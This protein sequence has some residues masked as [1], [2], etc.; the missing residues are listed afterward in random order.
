M[1]GD[2]FYVGL[3]LAFFALTAGLAS[4]AERIM[5]Q[6]VRERSEDGAREAAQ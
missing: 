3:V 2:F 6:P 1:N 5:P 4:F